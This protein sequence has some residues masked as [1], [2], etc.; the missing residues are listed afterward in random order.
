MRKRDHH[1]SISSQVGLTRYDG[2]LAAVI[3]S[4]SAKAQISSLLDLLD[5][6]LAGVETSPDGVAVL[7]DDPA[8]EAVGALSTLRT[9]LLG[10]IDVQLQTY[11]GEGWAELPHPGFD[12]ADCSTHYTNWPGLLAAE[13]T[14][15]PLV[16]NLVK[17]ADLPELRAY[18]L[19]TS[20]GWWSLRLEG[21][22]IGRVGAQQGKLGVGKPGK[23]GNISPERKAWIEAVGTSDPVTVDDTSVG[24]A[25]VAVQDFAH[26][27]GTVAE[28]QNEHVL[29]SRILRGKV[30]I[31][32][33][34]QPL[35]PIRPD[36][37]VN[38]GSQFPTKWGHGGGAR[39]LDA[40]LRDGTTPWAIEMKV[41]RSE[42]QY[43]RHAVAQAVL[44]RD[45]IRNATPLHF[46][47]HKFDLDPTTCR[48]AVVVP[49]I[50]TPGWHARLGA[51]CELFD[52]ELVIVDPSDA[53]RP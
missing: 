26:H 53:S 19:L 36:K 11:D 47:F 38:W 28:G 35:Q 49:T 32:A 23:T 17:A 29:E 27:W 16:T 20:K 5:L 45:F 46:W 24:S 51:V 43:Y 48:A 8:P 1:N 12:P 18:P 34:E 15:P 25:A 44:Y 6:H 33:G 7:L 22:E 14:V 39:Y 10:K 4:P 13:F 52:V 41:N 21:L 37:V 31:S 50:S 2:M 30:L 9:A 3:E 42:G 40:L